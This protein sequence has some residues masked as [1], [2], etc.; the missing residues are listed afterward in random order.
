MTER[1]RLNSNPR[2]EIY[3]TRNL[4]T[5]IT[6]L[7][8][9]R[10]WG[11]NSL[12]LSISNGGRAARGR[13]PQQKYFVL[14]D[15]SAL[16][17]NNKMFPGAEFTETAIK[18]EYRLALGRVCSEPERDTAS[19]EIE[20]KD[21]E[22]EHLPVL[23]FSAKGARH[24]AIRLEN[25]RLRSV[26]LHV[27]RD[28]SPPE[29]FGHRETT[30]ETL[31]TWWRSVGM[32]DWGELFVDRLDRGEGSFY[33]ELAAWYTPL[34]F[35]FFSSPEPLV[36]SR[37]LEAGEV[38][39]ARPKGALKARVLMRGDRMMRESLAAAIS[40]SEKSKEG[41]GSFGVSHG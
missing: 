38:P 41:S 6:E 5:M 8:S 40:S 37:R 3:E 10:R 24:V 1:K 31:N 34:F 7:R 22:K 25:K 4:R 14:R 19:V 27:N 21:N 28:S 29:L 26:T 36:P 13:L 9:N 20:W 2:A 33:S 18:K 23:L 15:S 16:M 30:Y 32:N 17:T 35:F 11:S 39:R 12:G